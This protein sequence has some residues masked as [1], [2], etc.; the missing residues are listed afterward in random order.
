MLEALVDGFLKSSEEETINQLQSQDN[1]TQ[2]TTSVSHHPKTD[3]SGKLMDFSMSPESPKVC[4]LIS[5]CAKSD[6]EISF[7]NGDIIDI[8]DESEVLRN[9][10]VVGICNGEKGKLPLFATERYPSY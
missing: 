3:V 8:I 7:E 4:A 5:Y 2:H 6:E 10:F 1:E 9:G